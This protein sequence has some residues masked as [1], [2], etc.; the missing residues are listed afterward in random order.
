MQVD[1]FNSEET[2][3]STSP[4]DGSAGEL[5]EALSGGDADYVVPEEKKKISQSTLVLIVLVALG[6]A[7]LYLMQL[8]TG[9]KAAA[10]AEAVEA[11]NTITTFLSG[12]DSNIKMMEQALRETEQ[13]VARFMKFPA[14]AQVPLHELQTNP[15]RELKAQEDAAPPS[16]V[17][18]KRRKE[19]ERQAVLKAVQMLQLQ[20]VMHGS[21]QKSAMINN[22]L[23]REGQTVEGFT[24]DKISPNA[25]VVRQGQ[26]RFELRMQR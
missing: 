3:E 9:P 22:A 20:S 18:S 17:V 23:Y 2:Q 4:G 12:G 5:S 25:V 1:N 6:G 7:G 10:A 24:V 13:I 14:A 11:N 16:D 21:S 15:F 26:Y 8:K 19:E